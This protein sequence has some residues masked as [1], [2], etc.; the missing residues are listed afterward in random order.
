MQKITNLS[1]CSISV[2]NLDE[3]N[4]QLLQC[5]TT[6][7]I[8]LLVAHHVDITYQSDF[9]TFTITLSFSIYSS[10]KKYKYLSLKVPKYLFNYFLFFHFCLLIFYKTN[11]IITTIIN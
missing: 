11:G 8:L 2:E 3:D 6:P 7:R 5:K 1:N 10:L 9:V 4:S